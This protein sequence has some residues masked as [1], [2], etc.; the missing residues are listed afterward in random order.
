MHAW[1]GPWHCVKD[2]NTGRVWEVKRDDESIHDGYWTYSW[3]LA[4]KGEQNQGDCYFEKAR[5]DTADLIRRTNALKLCGRS[6][7]RLPT[8]VELQSI[9]EIPNQPGNPSVNMFFFPQ[10]KH[11]DYWTSDD[12]KPLTGVYRHLKT[13]AAAINFTKGETVIIPYRN[14][15]FTRLIS[16]SDKNN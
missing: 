7:W 10:T 8:T 15:A 16:S 2:E 9:V 6:D 4:G 14:A 13:G 12:E 1:A 11:G 5:C 3:W